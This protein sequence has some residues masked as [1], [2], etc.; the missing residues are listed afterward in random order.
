MCCV[1]MQL[2][3]TRI[4]CSRTR[5]QAAMLLIVRNSTVIPSLCLAGKSTRG[6]GSGQLAD[7]SCTEILR[8]VIEDGR[9]RILANENGFQGG[10][11]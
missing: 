10:L 7:E 8:N 2:I 3:S 6:L 4:D 11:A 5:V 9:H 1:L